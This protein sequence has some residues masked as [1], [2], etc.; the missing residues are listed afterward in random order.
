MRRWF[1][2]GIVLVLG[3]AGYFCGLLFAV[4][5]SELPESDSGAACDA[6]GESWTFMWWLAVL[7]PAALFAG[8]RLIPILREHGQLTV[9]LTVV[10]I[11]AFW[12]PLFLT[13]P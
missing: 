1:A 10:L 12:T 8:S 11:V 4:G 9:F 6:I 2:I 7:W 13:D 3:I 5:C